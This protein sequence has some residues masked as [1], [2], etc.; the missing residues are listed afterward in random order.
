[1][2]SPGFLRTLTSH[3]W[4]MG[5]FRRTHHTCSSSWLSRA[6]SKTIA[7]EKSH[8][9]A[10]GRPHVFPTPPHLHS[11]PNRVW[12]RPSVDLACVIGH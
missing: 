11:V 3:G 1:M 5:V 9:C 6:G 7:N 2:Q 10:K 4:S 12:N 8:V